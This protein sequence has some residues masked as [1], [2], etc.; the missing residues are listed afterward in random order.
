M[1]VNLTVDQA[2][3]KKVSEVFVNKELTMKIK[4]DNE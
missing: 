4:Y 1:E 2:D 3:T